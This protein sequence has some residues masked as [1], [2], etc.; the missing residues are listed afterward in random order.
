MRGATTTAILPVPPGA[1]VDWRDG[2][3]RITEANGCR[4][5]LRSYKPPRFTA[6][7]VVMSGS[8]MWWTG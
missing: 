2:K 3:L 5:L 4:Y 6:A 1:V 8:G 7:L